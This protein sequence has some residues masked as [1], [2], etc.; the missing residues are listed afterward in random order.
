MEVTRNKQTAITAT[1]L[2]RVITSIIEDQTTNRLGNSPAPVGRLAFDMS[3]DM[4]VW[5]HEACASD[6]TQS[7]AI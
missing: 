6:G 7:I 3:S 2:V 4:N 5:E 1:N